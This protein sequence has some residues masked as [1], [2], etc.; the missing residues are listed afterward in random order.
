MS[1]SEMQKL[2][3]FWVLAKLFEDIPLGASKRYSCTPEHF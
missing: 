2:V 1:F 3:H